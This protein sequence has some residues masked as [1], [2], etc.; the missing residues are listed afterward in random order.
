MSHSRSEARGLPAAT[1]VLATVTV[2]LA[3]FIEQQGADADSVFGRAGL[4]VDLPERPNAPIALRDFCH[5][6][7][8]AVRRT[9]NDNFGLWFGAQ[10]AP[11][12]LGLLG[13][14]AL[15]SATL[16]QAIR[17]MVDHFPVHQQNSV[18]QLT[19]DDGICRLEYRVNDG[20]ILKRRQD[21]ELSLGMFCNVMRRALGPGWA[22]LEIQFEHARPG[23]W[24]D[25]RQ[26]FRSDV[27]FNQPSN[28][29]IFRAQALAR[30]MPDADARL[31][32]IIRQSLQMLGDGP[33]P[34]LLLAARVKAEM[35]GLLPA[36]EP[37]LEQVAER[38]RLP[39]WTLRR[40]LDEEGACFNSVLES[41]RRELAPV[42]LQ[43]AG[44]S[45]S[46]IAFRLG[47]TEV[48]AFSRAFVRWY[49]VSPRQWRRAA[50]AG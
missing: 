10:F 35:L 48:S 25:H 29:I 11:E 7:D 2:G 33:R 49:G 50:P 32:A 46:E 5:V 13:Y 44:V 36:G 31:L 47:Y 30:P 37:R 34:A 15:S 9:G 14:L 45:I 43:E 39:P 40:R 19:Q 4:R 6:L 22:P 23:V 17:N 28:V 27:R 3:A 41:L 20:A 24:Q 21:A 16:G 42:H 26:A 18:L 1:S 12:A 8:E 38:L